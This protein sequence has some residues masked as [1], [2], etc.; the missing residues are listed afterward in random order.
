MDGAQEEWNR[1]VELCPGEGEPRRTCYQQA[2]DERNVFQQDNC[3]APKRIT[4][5][6]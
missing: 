6:G 3:G 4:I 1:K 2:T 5:D